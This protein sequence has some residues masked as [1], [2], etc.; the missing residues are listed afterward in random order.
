VGA[1]AGGRKSW[2]ATEIEGRDMSIAG[3]ALPSRRRATALS[4]LTVVLLIA[5]G[6]VMAT[7]SGAEGDPRIAITQSASPNPV[8]SG[9]QLTYTIDM[10]NELGSRADEVTLTDQVAGMTDLVVTSTVGSCT[11][12]EGLVRCDAG[13]LDG[14]QPWRVT[15]RGT[16]TASNGTT[17]HNTASVTG[18]QSSQTYSAA[19]TVSTLVSTPATGNLPNLR[20]STSAATPVAPESIQTITLTVNNNGSSPASNVK[21]FHTLP[22][23]WTFTGYTASSLFSCLEA[24]GTVTCDGGAVN[25]GDNATISIRTKAGDLSI[26]P[27]GGLVTYDDHTS[28]VDPYDAITESNELDNTGS[29]RVLVQQP[30]P[31]GAL[32]LSKDDTTDPIRPGDLLTYTLKLKNASTGRVDSVKI[33]DGTQGLDASSIQASASIGTTA[34]PCTVSAS[35]VICTRTSPTLRLEAGQTMNMT[36]TGKV[37]ASAG[38]I[39]RNTATG[40]AN[41]KNKGQAVTATTLTSVR[42]QYD[43]TITQKAVPIE[44]PNVR[45]DDGVHNNAGFR[46]YDYY[47]YKITVGNSWLDDATN[48]RV[49][50]PLP[51]GVQFQ[52]FVATGGFNCAPDPSAL[53]VIDCTGGT[54]AG[55]SPASPGGTTE[56][57]TLFLITPNKIGPISATATVD[58]GNAIFEAEETNNTATTATNVI[59]GIDLV[60]DKTSNNPVAPSGTLTYAIRVRNLGTQDTTGVLVRDTLPAGTRFISAVGDPDHNFTCVHDGAATG[61]NVECTGGILSGTHAHT[62]APDEALITLVVFAPSQPSSIKNQLRVDPAQAIPEIFEDNNI[63][64]YTT[65]VKI[66]ETPAPGPG[67]YEAY[68]S[69]TIAKSAA[70]DPVAPSGTLVYTIT[71]K[72]HGSDVAFGV[73]VLDFLPEGAVFRS[74]DDTEP[75][76]G[77]FSCSE[78]GGVVRCQDGTLDGTLGQTQLANDDER[79]IKV[80]VFAP[81][82]P[83]TYSNEAVVDPS[84]ELPEANE[85]DNSALETVVVDIATGTGAY[86]ELSITK[87]KKAPSGDVAPSGELEWELTV[88]NT[89][90]DAV[91]DVTVR[92]IL[93]TGVTFRDAFDVSPSGASF[94]CDESNGIVECTG[95]DLDGLAPAD[96][97]PGG[98]NERKI[99]VQV[100]AQAQTGTYVNR[101]FVDP[102]DAIAEANETNNEA[103]NQYD[104]KLGGGGSYIDLTID[105][106]DDPGDAAEPLQVVT[107]ELKVT[108]TG[109]GDAF[110]VVVADYLPDN[111]TFVSAKDKVDSAGKFTCAQSGGIVTCSNGYIP[112]NNGTRTIVVQ[113]RAPNAHGVTMV[114]NAAVDPNNVIAESSEIN[115]TDSEETTVVSKVD[116]QTSVDISSLSSNNESQINFHGKNTGTSTARNVTVVLNL[117]V[118]VI[119]LDVEAPAG[120]TCGITENP[121]NQVTCTTSELAGGADDT[122]DVRVYTTAQGETVHANSVIDPGNTVAESSETNN[123]ATGST[124]V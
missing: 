19:S 34:V 38:S 50:E 95:G 35:Q 60:T 80:T 52:G 14:F 43:L 70:P 56:K 108:N 17:L 21:V 45:H 100:F 64:T 22:G 7:P 6:V 121:I 85:T 67:G 30:A 20:I 5:G 37:V 76:P 90:S 101:A 99:R 73:D 2:S 18:T 12:D 55:D 29:A 10:V 115:N 94:S 36:V 102:D 66:P 61:G 53:N 88:K 42:P 123:T 83:G 110:N 74:A 71:V 16:V 106:T 8:A 119:P 93:P 103:L 46:A 23:G 72:N 47:A 89:G 9:G 39:I 25:A 75:G 31:P 65:V 114:N 41:V 3:T 116:L 86:H 69:F 91:F 120:W 44:A 112:P 15:I 118:G 109:I 32:V 4:M 87:E 33:T 81:E 96:E 27:V 63:N 11:E 124:G 40:Q 59:T 57:I 97:V 51:D 84:D 79:Q 122:F 1:S 68:H 54:I 105:K 104:V 92:D 26:D 111:G 113:V 49:R 77:A 48:V 24:S 107:Y 62:L 13:S 98:T 28:V 78:D 58:P 117:P 82:Q